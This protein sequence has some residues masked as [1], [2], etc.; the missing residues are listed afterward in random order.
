MHHAHKSGQGLVEYG[1]VLAVI[2]LV[3]FFLIRATGIGEAIG[4]L[5]TRCS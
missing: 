2:V 4:C 5:V 3:L 1:L